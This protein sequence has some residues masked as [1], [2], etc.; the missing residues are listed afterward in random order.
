MRSYGPLGVEIENGKLVREE[1]EGK[2]G[3]RIIEVGTYM[4]MQLL[5]LFFSFFYKFIRRKVN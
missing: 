4:Y 2:K 1:R 5:F 3:I